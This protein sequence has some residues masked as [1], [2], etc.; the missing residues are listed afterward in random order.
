M[1]ELDV[2]GALAGT[3]KSSSVSWGWDYL[4]HYDEL[5]SRWRGSDI[6]M[7]E[8][9]VAGGASIATWHLYFDKAQLVGIDINPDCLQFARDRVAIRI[10]SQDDP[11]FL[12]GV[13]AEFP[14]TIVIDDGSHIAHHMVT[15]FETLFPALL[16]GGMY[17]F[18]DMAFHFED[19]DGRLQDSRDQQGLA[20]MPIY[21]YLNQF[22][23]ART[24]NLAVPQGSWGFAR[25]AYEQ[26]DSVT[27]MGGM[28]AVRKRAPRD[29][30]QDVAVFERELAEGTFSREAAM[31]RFAEFLVKHN[32]HLD[33]TV[34][35][36]SELTQTEP[37]NE[38]ALTMLQA[39]MAR[40]G[41]FDEA[42]DIA[43]RLTRLSPGNLTY[44]E[45]SA[46][47]ERLRQRFDLEAVALRHLI[48]AQ[49][50]SAGHYHRLSVSLEQIG[51]IGAAAKAAH[52][53][54]DFEPPN[55]FYSARR[56]A[57]DA[58]RQA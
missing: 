55:E 38:E 56:S 26:I 52:M 58:R 25:Y 8:V 17:V 11:G 29:L 43:T 39:L 23:R 22:S 44:L 42:A 15:M 27:V 35:L 20:A 3:D 49:P 12:H 7:I 31:L 14:P 5:F 37:T 46:E 19:K 9:G 40:L 53:A 33:R 21:E 28:I 47:S 6:N 54:C 4:R 16:P 51:D 45:T 32:I 34:E 48:D 1:S 24:A 36:L 30:E 10:G 18:E 13:A 2:I 57:L 41:R 50:N